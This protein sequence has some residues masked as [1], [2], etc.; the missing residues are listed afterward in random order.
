MLGVGPRFSAGLSRAMA[1]RENSGSVHRRQMPPTRGGTRSTGDGTRSRCA[2][3]PGPRS[4]RWCRRRHL[5]TRGGAFRCTSHSGMSR[6]RRTGPRA[7][8]ERRRPRGR[9]PARCRRS[10]GRTRAASRVGC[11]IRDRRTRSHPRRTGRFVCTGRRPARHTR[12]ACTRPCNPGRTRRPPVLPVCKCTPWRAGGGPRASCGEVSRRRLARHCNSTAPASQASSVR[13]MPRWSKSSH[14]DNSAP[15][16][17]GEFG[18][19]G[20]V[21]VGPP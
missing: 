3:T 11:C 21:H 15:P 8:R 16:T 17:A 4:C 12:P 6:R 20:M 13:G 1:S 14:S 7:C 18:V 19:G 2:H 5:C 9:T 10:K